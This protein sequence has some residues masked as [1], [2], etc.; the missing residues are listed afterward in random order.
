MP[1]GQQLGDGLA[2]GAGP[3]EIGA[4]IQGDVHMDAPGAGGFRIGGEPEVVEQTVQ[5]PGGERN[6]RE[7]VAGVEIEDHLVRVVRSVG[8]AQHR[9]QADAA[10][11]R[12]V[13][14][15]G[16]V[17]RDDLSQGS[18]L[19]G[20]LD[21]RDPV[22]KGGRRGLLHE[23]AVVDA[24]GEAAHGQRMALDEGD[25]VPRDALVVVDHVAL[26]DA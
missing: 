7:V 2:E 13:H 8:P 20:Q 19:L 21:G 25:H 23:A 10:Q 14:E 26:G 18:R 12:E 5:H 22:G 11:V 4:A 17:V 3:V 9:V 24:V 15:G 1:V 16:S 6:V